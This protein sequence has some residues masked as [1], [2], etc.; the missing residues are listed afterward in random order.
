MLRSSTGAIPHSRRMR[1]RSGFFWIQ[2]SPNGLAFME[3][4]LAAAYAAD[5][6]MDVWEQ[7]V[8]G[9]L[10]FT[11]PP[12]VRC[13]CRP[14]RDLHSLTNDQRAVALASTCC[15]GLPYILLSGNWSIPRW[16]YEH[17]LALR[18]CECC[19]RYGL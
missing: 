12:T 11:T 10:I 5:S 2:C 8:F 4:W 18:S 15:I 13:A 17:S 14:E 1:S 16:S 3:A 9:N 7:L 19:Q 6:L